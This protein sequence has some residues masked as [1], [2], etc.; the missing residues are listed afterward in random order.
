MRYN[1]KINNELVY[2]QKLIDKYDNY[3]LILNS[4]NWELH[5]NTKISIMSTW[6]FKNF[7]EG[8]KWFQCIEWQ[9]ISK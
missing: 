4:P 8:H 6:M 2:K 3:T 1:K 5:N 7:N 9:F